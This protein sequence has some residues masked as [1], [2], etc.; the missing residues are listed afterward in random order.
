MIIIIII[1]N[2]NNN[3]NSGTV[4]FIIGAFDVSLR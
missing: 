2:N 4:E 3:N 1:S